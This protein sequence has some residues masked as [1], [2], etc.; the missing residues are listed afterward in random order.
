MSAAQPDVYV[1]FH[2]SA[3]KSGLIADMGAEL[4]QTLAV[5]SSFIDGTGRC[6]PSQTLLAERLGVSR[7]TANRRI[8][9]LLR[10]RWR[11]QPIVTAVKMRTERGW[12]QTVYTIREVSGFTIY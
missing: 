3:A 4:F 7:E 6:F 12:A 5:L 1:K 10:Y 9:K 2:I 11:G 8:A